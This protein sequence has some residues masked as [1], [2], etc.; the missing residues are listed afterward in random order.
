LV[1]SPLSAVCPT[2]AGASFEVFRSP[3]RP[4]SLQATVLVNSLTLGRHFRVSPQQLADEF[5][6]DS[7]RVR[8]RGSA[9]ET[10][11]YRD[12]RPGGI[13]ETSWSPPWGQT[14]VRAQQRGVG[15]TRRHLPWGSA[16][17]G[18][19]NQGDRTVLVCLPNTFRSQG[20]SPSQRFHPARAVWLC[21]TPLPPIGFR[22]SELFPLSQ[23]WCLST[24]VPL[25]SFEPA[26]VVSSKL[27]SPLPPSSSAPMGPV[28][29]SSV[30]PVGCC[31]TSKEPVHIIQKGTRGKPRV[32]AGE[33]PIDPERY[34]AQRPTGRYRVRLQV[35]RKQ[36]PTGMGPRLQSLAP[37]ESPYSTRRRYSTTE[38][39]L[40]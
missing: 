34:D 1:E 17:F 9:L 16:P 26:R 35:L 21:F 2:E 6:S 39:M 12:L 5:L 24:L 38:P 31:T 28:L 27:V 18:G 22:S 19:K 40:S 11:R 20:F 15:G 30:N 14:E 25:L 4:T 8:A 32:R 13:Q 7:A 37:T 33:R 10:G 3:G 23:P 29:E 36:S